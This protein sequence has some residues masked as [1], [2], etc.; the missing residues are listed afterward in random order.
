[1]RGG[2]V[3]IIRLFGMFAT[4]LK[5]CQSYTRP[6]PKDGLQAIVSAPIAQYA[7]Q[8]VDPTGIS[9]SQPEM[10]KSDIKIISYNVLGV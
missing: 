10:T 5:F 6:L 4:V 7:K 1:M 3:S 8:W 9:Y 2:P